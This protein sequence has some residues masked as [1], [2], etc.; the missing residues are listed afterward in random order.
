M[1]YSKTFVHVLVSNGDR[2]IWVAVP[3]RVVALC[4]TFDG[5]NGFWFNEG[6]TAARDLLALSGTF[7]LPLM[8]P[9]RMRGARDS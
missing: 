8:S 7:V 2:L 9:E 6:R 5:V 1:C 4:A 3:S